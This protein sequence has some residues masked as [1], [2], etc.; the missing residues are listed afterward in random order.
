[1]GWNNG[2]LEGWN[3]GYLKDAIQFLFIQGFILAIRSHLI[4]VLEPI[5]PTFQYSNIPI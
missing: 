2:I 1:M 5:I 4:I 3:V